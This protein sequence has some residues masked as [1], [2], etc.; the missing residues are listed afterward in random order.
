MSNER[1]KLSDNP[2]ENEFLHDVL[3][4]EKSSGVTAEQ[5]EQRTKDIQT[6]NEVFDSS[7]HP[8]TD[9]ELSK[10][11]DTSGIN[12]GIH[13]TNEPQLG[14]VATRQNVEVTPTELPPPT[15]PAQ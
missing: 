13:N 11:V 2:S 10:I 4:K 3:Y 5:I 12:E 6:N 9:V 1:P 8:A 7:L 14:G 15:L